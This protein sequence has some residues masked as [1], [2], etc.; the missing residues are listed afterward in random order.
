MS[1]PLKIALLDFDNPDELQRI[2]RALHALTLNPWE[3]ILFHSLGKNENVTRMQYCGSFFSISLVACPKDFDDILHFAWRH[4]T[5]KNESEFCVFLSRDFLPV[6]PGW[7]H[8]LIQA[9][10]DSVK[11]VGISEGD[12]GFKE[13]SHSRPGFKFS[14]FESAAMNPS[15][16]PSILSGKVL[17]LRE[18]FKGFREYSLNG[19]DT[20]AVSQPIR[21]RADNALETL[22]DEK[23]FAA[24]SLPGK[25]WEVVDCDLCGSRE[26]KTLLRANDTLNRLPGIWSVVRC[27]K[28]D[29]NFTNPRPDEKTIL[30]FYPDTYGCH[31][32]V[33]PTTTFVGALNKTRRRTLGQHFGYF[34]GEISGPWI[35]KALTLPYR[36]EENISLTP[37][38][39]KDALA[40]K[41]LE[42]GCG[43]G[44]NLLA[45]KALGW[46]V[47]GAEPSDYAAGLARKSGINVATATLDKLEFP[48]AEFD[49][50]IM[51]MVLEHV[52]SPKRAI[53]KISRWLKPHGELLIA[54]PN[55]EG[56]EARV[57]GEF[58][59]GLQVPTHLYHFTPSTLR[60]LLRGFH[61][62]ITYHASYRDLWMGLHFY[63]RANPTSPW[64]HF[65]KLP[66]TVF[67]FGAFILAVLGKSS[68]IS[69]RATK[70]R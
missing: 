45:L 40:P 26:W 31:Q 1:N 13:A 14:L 68:R 35:W 20:L 47:E 39:P 29:L 49:A 62:Q 4:I 44:S 24:A 53:E 66:R 33:S 8:A 2:L 28:C 19:S 30:S 36:R 69:M 21:F 67:A 23:I 59:Y 12:Q 57:F 10:D 48:P 56:F 6:M 27:L 38:W 34:S 25:G 64:R 11:V 32:A 3:A 5:S 60:K 43:V 46:E 52:P 70:Q 22:L 15:E 16:L 65:L 41:L 54:V 42:I 17:E 18:D 63:L 51:E 55:F 9:L 50:I 37:R 7:D 61:T 58:H